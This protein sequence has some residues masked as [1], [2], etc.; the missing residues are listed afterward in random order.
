MIAAHLEPK[1][2]TP[3]A[4]PL[5]DHRAV[6]WAKAD[7]VDGSRRLRDAILGTAAKPPIAPT[8]PPKRKRIFKPGS[9]AW[10]ARQQTRVQ[11]LRIQ[12]EAARY[13]RISLDDLIGPYG[14]RKQFRLRQIAMYVARKTT[15]ASY[16]D[17][18]LC[19]GGRDHSTVIH[20]CRRVEADPAALHHVAALRKVLG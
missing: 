7:A 5:A 20:A 9:R 15:T 1:G 12:I 10:K 2:L 13:F 3:D 18:G 8:P 14:R 16:P 4:T 6:G 19:F 17:I 11:V